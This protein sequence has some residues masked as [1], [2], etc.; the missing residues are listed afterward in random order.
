MIPQRMLDK[1]VREGDCLMWTGAVTENGYGQAF[2][3]GKPRS[4]HRAA[5]LA[6][7]GPIPDDLTIDHLCRHKLCI[8]PEHMELVT[9]GE[10]VRRWA[11]SIT[12]CPQGHDYSPENTYVTRDGWRQCKTCRRARSAAWNAK[13]KQKRMAVC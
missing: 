8:N 1:T 5:Y 9:R 6:T 3:D 13:Q 10:N 11:A 12:Q 2:Y 7:I 4:A